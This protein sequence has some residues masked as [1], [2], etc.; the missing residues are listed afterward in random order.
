MDTNAPN[1]YVIIPACVAIV[2]AVAC[3]SRSGPLVRPTTCTTSRNFQ[4]IPGEER[5]SMSAEHGRDRLDRA[6]DGRRGRGCEGGRE[7]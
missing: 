4:M 2:V 5:Y 3:C 6:G 7:T 1:I